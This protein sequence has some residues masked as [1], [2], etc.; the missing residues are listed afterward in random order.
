MFRLKSE[1]RNEL[2]TDCKINI[3]KVSIFIKLIYGFNENTDLKRVKLTLKWIENIK[4]L[5]YLHVFWREGQKG[6]VYGYYE[7]KTIENIKLSLKKEK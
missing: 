6:R 5:G 2:C 3:I 7:C 1:I 4:E